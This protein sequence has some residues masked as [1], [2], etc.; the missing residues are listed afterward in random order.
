VQ[1]VAP[2]AHK[3]QGTVESVDATAAALT[4]KHGEIPTLNWPAMTM[5]FKVEDSALLKGVK[6]GQSVQFDIAQR[7]PG[8]FVITRI[9]PAKAAGRKGN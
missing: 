7:A 8:E 2:Q 1:S 5:A 9:A 4:I 6:P 3:G